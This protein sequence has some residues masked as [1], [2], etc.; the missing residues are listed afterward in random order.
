MGEDV[1]FVLKGEALG[2]FGLGVEDPVVG[3]AVGLVE[4]EFIDAVVVGVG[5]G[6]DF[7]AEVGDEG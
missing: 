5:R 2:G 6:E 7:D 4:V 3:D 1:G